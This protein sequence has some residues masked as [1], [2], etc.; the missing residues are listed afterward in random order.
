MFEIDCILKIQDEHRAPSQFG[1]VGD[2]DGILHLQQLLSIIFLLKRSM[3][4]SEKCH[5]E[6][7]PNLNK[8]I[9][10]GNLAADQVARAPDQYSVK[11]YFLDTFRLSLL[12][13]LDN[14]YT[15]W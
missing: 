12:A 6:S 14:R 15:T 3:Y 1:A 5:S 4:S 11:C 13:C 10:I 9:T 8:L 2:T 7:A